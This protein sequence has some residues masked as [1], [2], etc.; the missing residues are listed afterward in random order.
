[1]RDDSRLPKS[2][3]ATP[4]ITS[5]FDGERQWRGVADPGR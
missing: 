4:A 3:A 2:D 1:M 5:L